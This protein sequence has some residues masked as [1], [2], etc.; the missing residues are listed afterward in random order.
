VQRFGGFGQVQIAPNRLLYKAELMKVH[1]VYR[2]S[3]A[4]IMP[5][6]EV[7]LGVG[8]MLAWAGAGVLALA[9]SQFSQQFGQRR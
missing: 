7:F 5:F 3:E 2:I 8:A 9:Q 6:I 4:F 1:I